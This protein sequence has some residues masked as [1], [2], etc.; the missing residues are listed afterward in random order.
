M[1]TPS[2]DADDVYKKYRQ[3][4]AERNSILSNSTNL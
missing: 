2:A 3:L 4:I 1:K